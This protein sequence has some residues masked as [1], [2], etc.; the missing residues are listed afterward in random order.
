MDQFATVRQLPAAVA[1]LERRQPPPSGVLSVY[2]DTSPA[3][4]D[5]E[6]FLLQYR[7]LCKQVRL[8][9]R[10]DA[11]FEAAAEQAERFLLD[12]FVQDHQGLA[13]FSAEDP[14]Y[15]QALALPK[16]PVPALA[17]DTLP[18]LAPVLRMLEDEERV[19]VLLFDSERARLFTVYLGEIEERTEL[20]DAVAR[21]Q[22]TGG[23]FGLR[24]TKFARQRE[25]QVAQ[26]AA[27]AVRAL[28]DLARER[29]FERLIIGG[30]DEPV[31]VLKATLPRP[32]RA[33]TASTLRLELFASDAQ[34]LAAVRPVLEELERAQELQAVRDL[35]DAA[36]SKLAAVGPEPAFEA[37]SEGRAHR[38]FLGDIAAAAYCPAC[39]RLTVQQRCPSCGAPPQPEPATA[40]RAVRQ[41]LAQGALVEFVS[42]AAAQALQPHGG[43]AAW[44]RY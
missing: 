39:D 18:H 35:L 21:R 3:A 7:D 32:L 16:P 9:G 17:W 28:Q 19:A 2:L 22:S 31:A 5:K 26:H 41:A 42:G 29:P 13:V 23:W 30:P 24:Q 44:T 36:T 37:L 10:A 27:R 43:I 14:A 38:V 8:E 1:A 12:T 25:Q 33:R 20:F 6:A 4:M 40:E 11:A 34:V 15:F